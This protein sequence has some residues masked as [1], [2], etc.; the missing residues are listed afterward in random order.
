MAGKITHRRKNSMKENFRTYK[1]MGFIFILTLMMLAYVNQQVLIYQMGLRVKDN[2]QVY[3]KLVDHNKISVY[4]V[5]NLKSPVSLQR[6]LL[7]K[8]VELDM[9][10]KWQVVKLEN[11]P[12]KFVHKEA[13]KKGL[14]ANLFVVS[15]EAEA[16]PNINS[17][18]PL[19]Y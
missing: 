16:S 10:R 19:S 2:Y 9:P 5:L 6:K 4:N 8:K 15:R 17:L 11:S 1:A 12:E 3:S 18:V 14:F 13:A 7:S